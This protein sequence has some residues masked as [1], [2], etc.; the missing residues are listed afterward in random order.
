V[1]QLTKRTEYGLI[2]MVHMADR[3]GEVVS[4]REIGD[5]Y[6]IPRR[7]LAE[8]LKDLCRASLVVSQRGATGGYMLVRSADTITLG[9][10]VA[11]LEGRPALSSCENHGL[12]HRV[13][14]DIEGVCPIRSPLQRVREGIWRL[15][16]RTTLR[17]LV[18]PAPRAADPFDSR[19]ATTL[20]E[21]LLS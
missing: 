19:Q 7:L 4:V 14:C 3:E 13:E 1:L 9:E 8:A 18:H 5:R 10:I 2:A 21:T 15:M 12:T 20:P 17:S 6:P 11:A 16:E